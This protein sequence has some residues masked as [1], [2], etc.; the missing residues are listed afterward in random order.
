MGADTYRARV[1]ALLIAEAL[2]IHR[3]IHTKR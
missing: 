1:G 2:D 3:Q